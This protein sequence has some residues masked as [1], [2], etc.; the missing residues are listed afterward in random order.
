M[1]RTVAPQRLHSF[2][3][4]SLLLV[5]SLVTTLLHPACP[6]DN[7][8]A[9]RACPVSWLG[10]SLHANMQQRHARAPDPPPAQATGNKLLHVTVASAP[11][12]LETLP[13][14]KTMTRRPHAC[15]AGIILAYSNSVAGRLSDITTAQGSG[16][17]GCFFGGTAATLLSGLAL[18]VFSRF[19]ELGREDIALAGTAKR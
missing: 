2:T 8:L 4:S 3:A 10:T 12:T 19:G 7:L 17:I 11:Q 5:I 15:P 18:L 13:R 1:I 9:H 16:N 6:G 14:H